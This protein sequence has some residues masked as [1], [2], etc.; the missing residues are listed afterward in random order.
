[1]NSKFYLKEKNQILEKWYFK[2]NYW[3]N[4][5]GT[6]I[7]GFLTERLHWILP[8]CITLDSSC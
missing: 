7:V 3:T 4:P 2:K 6:E 1:M 5:V 8:A